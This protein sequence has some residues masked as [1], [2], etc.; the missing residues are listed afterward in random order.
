MASIEPERAKAEFEDPRLTLVGQMEVKLGDVIETAPGD[1]LNLLKQALRFRIFDSPSSTIFSVDFPRTLFFGESFIKLLCQARRREDPGQSPQYTDLSGTVQ[2]WEMPDKRI[3]S[4]DDEV[5]YIDH[6]RG[7]RAAFIKFDMF[8]RR[9]YLYAAVPLKP[10]TSRDFINIQAGRLLTAQMDKARIQEVEQ[11]IVGSR[12]HLSAVDYSENTLKLE[13][14]SIAYD[15]LPDQLR[16]VVTYASIQADLGDKLVV[17]PNTP[18]GELARGKSDN[19][20]AHHPYS[21]SHLGSGI[22]EIRHANSWA[23]FSCKGEYPRATRFKLVSESDYY[24]TPVQVWARD[25]KSGERVWMDGPVSELLNDGMDQR[26]NLRLG[27]VLAT[28]LSLERDLLPPKLPLRPDGYSQN[29]VSAQIPVLV[30]L[31]EDDIRRMV[32]GNKNHQVMDPHLAILNGSY[33]R[34]MEN[35]ALA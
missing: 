25:K 9:R 8:D 11:A 32:G 30:Y 15:E 24:L 28:A 10:E 17:A 6:A 18:L 22:V 5:Q 27:F 14:T 35:F 33:F 16:A 20:P 21:I 23:R 7:L 4:S 3:S 19:Y 26:G 13:D 31:R 34:A 12:V 1:G 29:I 2:D